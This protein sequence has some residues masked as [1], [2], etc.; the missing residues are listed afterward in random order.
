[1]QEIKKYIKNGFYPGFCGEEFGAG[2]DTVR[3]SLKDCDQRPGNVRELRD[4][5]DEKF[6]HC[7]QDPRTTACV[8]AKMVNLGCIGIDE[9]ENIVYDEEKLWDRG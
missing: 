8:I 6:G 9:D 7:F 3:L 1:M 2:V 4:Y 5:I